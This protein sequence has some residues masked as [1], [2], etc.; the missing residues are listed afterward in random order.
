M[1]ARKFQSQ[2]TTGEAFKGFKL[3]D[4]KC[5]LGVEAVGDRYHILIP[6][7]KSW[8]ATG[9][10]VFSTFRDNQKEMCILVLYG[11]SMK[12][13]ENRLLGQ[14][15]MVNIPPAPK[16]VPAMEVTFRID[17]RGYLTAECKDLDYHRHKMWTQNG[18]AMTVRSR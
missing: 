11:N 17:T 13:S 7:H 2:T 1:P 18:G 15:D 8:P 12:A 3:P 5:H 4:T 14:F 6:K 10:H 9:T 16:Q